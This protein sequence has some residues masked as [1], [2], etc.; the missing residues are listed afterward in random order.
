ML[1]YRNLATFH[2]LRYLRGLAELMRDRGVRFFAKTPVA[3][4]DEQADAV[5]VRTERVTPSPRGTRS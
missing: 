4:I 5:V 2:P 1:H 3:A